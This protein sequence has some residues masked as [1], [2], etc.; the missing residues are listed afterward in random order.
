MKKLTEFTA[1]IM[2]LAVSF[3]QAGPAA[4]KEDAHS[5]GTPIWLLWRRARL[6]RIGMVD[7]IAMAL[8][9]NSDIQVRKIVPRI[10]DANVMIQR[11]RFEPDF[12]LDFLIES[13]T[14][15]SDRPLFGPDP[16]KVRTNTLNFGWDQKLVHRDGYFGQYGQ[17]QGSVQLRP[18]IPVPQP[19]IRLVC[20]GDCDSA[21][22]ERLR[23]HGQ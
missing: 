23:H 1:V 17:Y 2:A 21:A 3:S 13:D 5:I 19:H 20:V 15:Q 7:C 10:E 6:L 14:D 11:A 16:T 4:A 18:R 12:T 22:P 8:K 9:N